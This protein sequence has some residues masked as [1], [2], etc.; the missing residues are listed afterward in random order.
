MMSNERKMRALKNKIT[1]V[2][3]KD[4]LS[5]EEALIEYTP[6]SEDTQSNLYECKNGFWIM[7]IKKMIYLAKGMQKPIFL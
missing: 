7:L 2:I 6:T 3:V 1:P 5:R 4:V